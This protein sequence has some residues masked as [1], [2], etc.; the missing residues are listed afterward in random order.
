MLLKIANLH[1]L[2]SVSPRSRMVYTFNAA[3]NRHMLAVNEA[4]GFRSVGLEGAW[5]D[6]D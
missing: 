1:R 6:R 3:E 2:A 5:R 4:L